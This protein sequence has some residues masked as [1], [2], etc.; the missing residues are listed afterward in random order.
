MMVIRRCEDEDRPRMLSIVND[1]ARRY[2][3]VI[4]ADRW[5]DPYMSEVELD[6]EAAA[7]V[8]FHGCVA[9]GVLV[10]IMGVQAA[11]DVTLIRHAYVSS[12]HQGRG[13]GGLLLRH[14]RARSGGRML[15]GTWAAAGWAIR[16]YEANGF[17]ALGRG[18]GAILLR[19]Y[20]SVPER[21]V[22]ESVVVASG[23][24]DLASFG[25]GS[26]ENTRCGAGVRKPA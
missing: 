4:P 3:G 16:F 7:G 19:R 5:H 1:A 22:E 13:V 8:D 2:A 23:P 21:Q 17:T 25:P 11:R 15:V 14:L 26:A 10:G 24:W 9:D 12:R 18:E 6:G 20:W